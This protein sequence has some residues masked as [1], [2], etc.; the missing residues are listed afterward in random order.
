MNLQGGGGVP[1]VQYILLTKSVTSEGSVIV[2]NA[3]WQLDQALYWLNH[4][5]ENLKEYPKNMKQ[6]CRFNLFGS[7]SN[8]TI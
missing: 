6:F 3:L 2:I 5:E 1:N 8:S 4:I 7:E